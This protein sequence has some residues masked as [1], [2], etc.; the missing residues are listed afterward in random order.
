MIIIK[1]VKTDWFCP[2]FSNVFI[3]YIA[4]PCS[5]YGSFSYALKTYL[6]IYHLFI[7]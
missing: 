5:K 4:Y 2:F 1:K 6:T 3:F 7:V